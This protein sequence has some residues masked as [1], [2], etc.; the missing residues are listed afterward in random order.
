MQAPNLTELHVYALQTPYADAARV[1]D[2]CC[3]AWQR[4]Y[5]GEAKH[6]VVTQA[7]GGRLLA[8]QS[9]R[10]AAIVIVR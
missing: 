4:L 6:T 10:A 3:P 1:L 8:K 5:V 7:L 2:R 9:G